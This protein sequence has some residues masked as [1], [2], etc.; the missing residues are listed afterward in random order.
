M[1]DWCPI[2]RVILLKVTLCYG[3]HNKIWSDG[4]LSPKAVFKAVRNRY[5]FDYVDPQQIQ[6][7]DILF[8]NR[9]YGIFHTQSDYKFCVNQISQQHLHVLELVIINLERNCFK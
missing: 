7:P 1:I 3:N 9:I 2:H 8:I 5:E 4:L 6:I